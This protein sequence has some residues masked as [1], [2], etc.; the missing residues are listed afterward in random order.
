MEA[1][2]KVLTATDIIEAEEKVRAELDERWSGVHKAFRD[3][4]EE[5][6]KETLI[7]LK[8]N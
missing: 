5:V 3:W 4:F 1:R 8:K 6:C 2:V 7:K